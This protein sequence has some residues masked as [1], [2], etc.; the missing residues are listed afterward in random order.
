VHAASCELALDVVAHGA[1]TD[2]DQNAALGDHINR[3]ER[4]RQEDR[5]SER[6]EHRY[7]AEPDF[8]GARCQRRHC[9]Q[10]IA[11]RLVQNRH[12]IAEPDM[13]KAEILGLR[14][15]RPQ[16]IETLR[17]IF[18]AHELTRVQKQSEFHCRFKA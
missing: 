18:R 1:D 4:V 11:A 17:C 15:V 3:G 10:A 2:A 13:I 14:R 8:F 7:G 12:A 6:R 5:I 9:G 16:L